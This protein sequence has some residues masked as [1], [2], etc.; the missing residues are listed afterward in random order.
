METGLSSP[1]FEGDCSSGS[2]TAHIVSSKALNCVAK[3]A[4]R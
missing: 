1:D 2:F 4:Y 3:H